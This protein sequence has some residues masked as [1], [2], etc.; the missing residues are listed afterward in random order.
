MTRRAFRR[1]PTTR[2]ARRIA[3]LQTR[4]DKSYAE[5][6]EACDAEDEAKAEKL[7]QRRDQLVG[8]MQ[9]AEDALQG[10]A[11]AVR[12]VAVAIVTLDRNGAA[13]LHRAWRHESMA[14]PL[15]TLENKTGKAPWR[16][17]KD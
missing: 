2:E 10:S 5:L 3:S 1:E 16:E 6:E 4:L 15:R 8:E 9:D 13:V 7:E 14:Q 11:P 17:E 12:Q